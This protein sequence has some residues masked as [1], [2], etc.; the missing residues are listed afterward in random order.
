MRGHSGPNVTRRPTANAKHSVAARVEL[1]LANLRRMNRY[2]P[3]HAPTTSWTGSVPS[4]A[5]SNFD[6]PRSLMKNLAELVAQWLGLQSNNGL[7][8][9]GRHSSNDFV[10]DCARRRG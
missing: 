4:V 9:G 5:H 6:S 1:G 2:G 7:D 8:A 3:C 10:V